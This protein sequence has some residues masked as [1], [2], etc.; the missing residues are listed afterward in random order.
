MTTCITEPIRSTTEAK[1]F[2]HELYK[3]DELFHPDDDARYVNFKK[4]VDDDARNLLN[5][6]MGEAVD[7]FNDRG[8]DM[9]EYVEELA[10]RGI[11]L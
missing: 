5:D 9:A 1:E 3:N 7:T 2:L 11:P 6:R 4:E 8:W 10:E